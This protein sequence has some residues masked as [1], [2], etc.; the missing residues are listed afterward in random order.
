M[1]ATSR[2]FLRAYARELGFEVSDVDLAGLSQQLQLRMA[3][4]REIR[5]QI[6]LNQA[7][8]TQTAR[9][10]QAL[11]AA[12]PQV[13]ALA[14]KLDELV[15][16]AASTSELQ[17]ASEQF[18]TAGLGLAGQLETGAALAERLTELDAKLSE[19]RI[20]AREKED[21]EREVALTL[22]QGLGLGDVPRYEEL[23]E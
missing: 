17:L 10:A 23:L 5:S 14:E 6:A 16:S 7:S 11:D 13:Y 4:L 15:K 19:L 9:E 2:G 22:A 12:A 21:R 18:V 20:A 3:D 8:K 1:L